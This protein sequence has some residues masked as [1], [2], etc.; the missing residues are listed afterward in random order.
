MPGPNSLTYEQIS[1]ELAKL[2][3]K[4]SRNQ[5]F[6]HRVE[7]GDD[8]HRIDDALMRARTILALIPAD[9]TIEEGRQQLMEATLMETLYNAAPMQAQGIEDFCR[10]ILAHQRLGRSTQTREQWEQKKGQQVRDAV[11]DLKDEVRKDLE[12]DPE[13]ITKLYNKIAA[14]EERMLEKV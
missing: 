14:A 10:L 12:G 3:H 9:T 4:I 8:I 6:K 5:I 11:K 1:E 2:G 7:L 13:L